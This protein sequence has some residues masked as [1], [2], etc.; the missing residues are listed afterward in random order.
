MNWNSQNWKAGYFGKRI[1]KQDSIDNIK[2]ESENLVAIW[3]YAQRELKYEVSNNI[4]FI[5]FFT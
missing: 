3:I 4:K 1:E 5:M 2:K